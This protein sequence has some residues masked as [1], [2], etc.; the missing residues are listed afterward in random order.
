MTSRTP[1]LALA[2]V[3]LLGGPNFG[4]SVEFLTADE[5]LRAMEGTYAAHQAY[6]DEG[7]AVTLFES[8]TG[9]W[10]ERKPFLTVFKRTAESPLPLLRYEFLAPIKPRGGQPTREWVVWSNGHTPRSWSSIRGEIGEHESMGRALAELAG[11][12]GL[13]SIEVA[14]LLM[15]DVREAAVGA[16]GLVPSGSVGEDWIDDVAC[17]VLEVRSLGGLSRTV[18]IEQ[19]AFLLRRV[20][21]KDHFAWGETTSTL[22]I[23][24]AAAPQLEPSEFDFRPPD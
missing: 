6:R 7:E 3:I 16:W 21:W 23:R 4:A 13:S 22:N 9:S 8:D 18:W 2:L 5:I 24:P 20:V 12:S 17:Y 1:A 19:Q 10:T 14:T 15:P 11:V